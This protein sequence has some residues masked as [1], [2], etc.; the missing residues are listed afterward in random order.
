MPENTPCIAANHETMHSFELLL[1]FFH[2]TLIMTLWLRYPAGHSMP[3]ALHIYTLPV[4]CGMHPPICSASQWYWNSSLLQSVTCR[5]GHTHTN[6]VY[7]QLIKGK[8]LTNEQ[9]MEPTL[10]NQTLLSM[11]VPALP[12]ELARLKLSML[13]KEAW[14][15]YVPLTNKAWTWQ[16]V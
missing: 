2:P 8:T 7:G 11:D 15:Y 10:G 9:D 12:V 1:H 14:Y 5:I 3:P 16:L 6:N 4:V 13:E